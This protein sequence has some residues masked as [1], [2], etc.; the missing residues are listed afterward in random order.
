MAL[1]AEEDVLSLSHPTLPGDGQRVAV[2]DTD[3]GQKDIGPPA[4]L[5]LGYPEMAQ[6]LAEAP[7]VA[8]YFLGPTSRA[9]HLLPMIVGSPGDAARAAAYI[10]I[11]TTAL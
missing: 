9:G 4:T 7:L 11:N 8:W 10:I 5:T 3:V 2:V 6:S 1:I